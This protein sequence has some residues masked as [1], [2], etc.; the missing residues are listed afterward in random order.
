MLNDPSRG[1]GGTLIVQSA[2]VPPPVPDP[3]STTPVRGIPVY[4][5]RAPKVTPQLVLAV[6]QYNRLVRMLQA[7][8]SLKMTVDL[9]VAWPKGDPEGL[10]T[11]RGKT[12]TQFKERNPMA[13]G[14]NGTGTSRPRGTH[15]GAGGFV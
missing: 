9:G 15:H 3:N 5:K 11:S 6:E 14:K 13:S 12:R 8:E 7:G 2:S 10:K 4:D 1:N